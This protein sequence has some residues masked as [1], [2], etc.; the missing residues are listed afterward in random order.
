M[1]RK[2]EI[3]QRFREAVLR[4]AGHR[5]EACGAEGVDRQGPGVRGEAGQGPPCLDAHHVADRHLFP[6]GGYV[7]ANGICLCDGCHAK[8]ERFHATGLA[9]DGYAPDDLYRIISSSFAEA[10]LDDSEVG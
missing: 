3:R 4:R 10:R 9:V 1:S 7:P 6:N 5:C 8:A 2:K